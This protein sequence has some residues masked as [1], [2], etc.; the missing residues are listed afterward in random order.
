MIR[1]V[2]R[3]CSLAWALLCAAGG[4]RAA[5]QVEKAAA[6]PIVITVGASQNWITDAD[7]AIAADFEKETGIK[8]DFH[9]NPD[10]QYYDIIRTKINT[11]E[12]P[13]VIMAH[14]GLT[15]LKLPQDMLLDL[16]AEPWVRRLKD[17]ARAGASVDGRLVALNTWSVGGWG[18]VYD[19]ALF[20]KLGV[21]APRDYGGLLE[22]CAAIAATGMV[23]DLR[24]GHRPVAHPPLA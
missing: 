11:G 2:P 10:S 5:P 13:D 24:M 18:V 15:L 23:P 21:S 6:R 4:L 22:V 19:P 20:R 12:A 16:Q 3:I 7:R 8:V 17:W 14:A 9:V 1:S